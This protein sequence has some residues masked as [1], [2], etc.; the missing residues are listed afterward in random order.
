[1]VA[2]RV[3]TARVGTARA[4]AERGGVQKE[5][6]EWVG[7]SGGALSA[8]RAAARVRTRNRYVFGGG[9]ERDTVGSGW[10]GGG[11]SP[12]DGLGAGALTGWRWLAPPRST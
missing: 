3:W 2:A 6:G 1:M 8:A 7:A 11:G 5:G 4:E 12:L 9:D 10:S